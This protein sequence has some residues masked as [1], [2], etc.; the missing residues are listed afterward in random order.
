MAYPYQ[1]LITSMTI[2]EHF[3]E[4]L[5]LAMHNQHVDVEDETAVYVVNLLAQ[6]SQTSAL[7]E[8]TPE[9]LDLRPLAL[10]YGDALEASTTQ[11]R[12]RALQH[13]G[14]LALFIAG[15]FA[16]SLNRKLVDIDYYIAMGGAAYS[17]LNDSFRSG[18][19]A[20]IFKVIFTELAQKFDTLVD[21]LGEINE[22]TATNSNS[23]V[24]RLYEVWLRTGSARALQKLQRLGVQPSENATSRSRH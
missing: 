20:Q 19:D 15:L 6:F 21:V 13:L 8:P 14:D 4:A 18:P 24:L 5:T 11:D 12:K 1:G 9:G 3:H 10:L 2:R 7:F 23:D 17:C 22:N 16:D